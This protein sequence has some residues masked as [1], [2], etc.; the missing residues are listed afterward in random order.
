MRDLFGKCIVIHLKYRNPIL[1]I[2]CE[3][4]ILPQ[5]RGLLSLKFGYLPKLRLSTSESSV[6]LIIL[7]TQRNMSEQEKLPSG[8]FDLVV[9]AQ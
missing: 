7:S 9:F 6:M 2:R 1:L 3:E 4:I 8:T 5:R